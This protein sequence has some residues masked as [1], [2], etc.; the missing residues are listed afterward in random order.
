MTIKKIRYFVTI[1]LLLN[2]VSAWPQ[3]LGSIQELLRD[4]AY[5][6]KLPIPMAGITVNSEG[7]YQGDR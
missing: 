1:C 3:D 2:T 7:K 6:D 5:T 4:S